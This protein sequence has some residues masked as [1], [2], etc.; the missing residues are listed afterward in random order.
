[1]RIRAAIVRGGEQLSSF[2]DNRAGE[3]KIAL[4]KTHLIC[5]PMKQANRQSLPEKEMNTE[6]ITH[7]IRAA[8]NVLTY[9]G[10]DVDGVGFAVIGSQSAIGSLQLDEDRPYRMCFTKDLDL[11]LWGCEDEEPSDLINGARGEYSR[12]YSTNGYFADGIYIDNVTLPEHW[13]ERT[14]YTIW[15]LQDAENNAVPVRF[16]DFHDLLAA[17]LYA[18]RGKDLRFIAAAKFD[19]TDQIDENALHASCLD[20]PVEDDEGEGLFKLYRSLTE[21]DINRDFEF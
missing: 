15:L 19:L 16:I 3:I 5:Y 11:F 21:D 13:E 18:G 17:K 9:Q 4:A 2:E 20:M 14:R 7:V 12:F 6:E 1:M 8:R 10:F